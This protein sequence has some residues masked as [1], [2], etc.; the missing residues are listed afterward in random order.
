ML[1]AHPLEQHRGRARLG[2]PAG[3][4]PAVIGQHL[5]RNPVSLHRRS[6]RLGDRPRGRDRQHR[7]ADNVA[8]V[9]IDAGQH[10]AFAAVSQVDPADQVQLP[11]RHRRLPGPPPVLALM[12]LGL[13]RHH[14]VA[15]Q[16][17]VHRRPRRRSRHAPLRHLERDPP[18]TPP[19][20]RPPQLAYQRLGLRR[21]P[22]RRGPRPPRDLTQ[23]VD[24]RRGVPGLPRIH[25]LPRHPY[26]TA[27]SPTGDPSSTSSTARSRCSTSQTRSS[28]FCSAPMNRRSS[29]SRTATVKHLPTT[30]CQACR[31]P[32]HDT[33]EHACHVPAIPRTV[34]SAGIA[35]TRNPVSGRP[36]SRLATCSQPR[37]RRKCALNGGAGSITQR[38][39]SAAGR[40]KPSAGYVR[41]PR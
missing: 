8:G 29:R 6:E 33:P 15:D 23:P 14:R 18:G 36:A 25:R 13:R 37:I 20:M 9:V 1:A 22:R 38:E 12:H 10:L 5:G 2:E 19:R 39:A 21:Q 11:Q 28:C 27:T 26:R 40:R 31:G 7:R 24:P 17:P 34:I 16:D 35:D 41:L 30:N 4:L 3:E 32:S